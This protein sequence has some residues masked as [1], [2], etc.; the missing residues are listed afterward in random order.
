MGIAWHLAEDEGWLDKDPKEL[1]ENQKLNN[2]LNLY[3][4]STCFR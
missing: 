2:R 4:F 1:I 3:D